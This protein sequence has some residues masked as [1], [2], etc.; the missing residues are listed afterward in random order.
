MFEK[1]ERI[2]RVLLAEDNPVD[3]EVFK[4]AARRSEC[5]FDLEVVID[6]EQA[7]NFL[8]K[9]REWADVW[10]PDFVVLNINMPK[11]NGWEVLERM[12]ADPDLAIL[13][14][15]MWTIA[16]PECG[17][18]DERAFKMGCS[19]GFTKPSD[20]IRLESQVTSMLEFYWWAWSHPLSI[21]EPGSPTHGA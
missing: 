12:K 1:R 9:K 6:G 14:V 7:L 20:P 10:T 21:R 17:D 19:G 2:C 18:Y 3:I 13:P 16:A 15:A 11:I 5:H 8:Q 4:R